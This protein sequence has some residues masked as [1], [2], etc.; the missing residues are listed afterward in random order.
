LLQSDSPE[1]TRKRLQPDSRLWRPGKRSAVI[2]AT[3]SPRK[4]AEKR[5]LV[6]DWKSSE[7]K[8]SAVLKTHRFMPRFL[9]A[10]HFSINICTAAVYSYRAQDLPH[11]L[12]YRV[13]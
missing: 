8:C 3:V 11:P 9:T 2:I 10:D 13:S 7:T 4:C 12:V 5:N 6:F 1:G